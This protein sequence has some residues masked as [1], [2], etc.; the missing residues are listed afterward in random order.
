MRIPLTFVFAMIA[1]YDISLGPEKQPV[2]HSNF[3][4]F[5]IPLL[6]SHGSRSCYNDDDVLAHLILSDSLALGVRRLYWDRLQH[7]LSPGG[8]QLLVCKLFASQSE[9]VEC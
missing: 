7:I 4:V 8:W 3:H 9:Y 1:L 2:S 5:T 6:P